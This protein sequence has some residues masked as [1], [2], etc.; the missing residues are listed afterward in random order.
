MEN[1]VRTLFLKPLIDSINCP[2]CH[3]AFFGAS[4]TQQ[5]MGYV[6]GFKKC[7]EEDIKLKES[8]ISQLGYGSLH[9]RESNLL[10]SE[11]VLPLHEKNRI[12]ICI[13]EWFTS[14]ASIL[15]EHIN[16]LLTQ[17]LSQ[18][19]LPVFLLLYNNDNR[20]ERCKTKTIYYKVA[21]ECKIPLIDIDSYIQE[22]N[23]FTPELFR[24]NTHLTE[25]GGKKV[26][27]LLYQTLTS[28]NSSIYNIKVAGR[29]V[30]VPFYYKVMSTLTVKYMGDIPSPAVRLSLTD[31]L[32]IPDNIP[33]KLL[34]LWTIAGPDSGV[35]QITN[36]KQEEDKMSIWDQWSH[37]D[38]F[39]I[40]RFRGDWYTSDQLKINLTTTPPNYSTCR[41]E[42]AEWPERF[43]WVIGWSLLTN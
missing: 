30:F 28:Y 33:G 43:F 10:L 8:T 19:I 1:K 27:E 20:V 14:E 18:H 3:I 23:L 13:L 37:Y 38:R 32:I 4:V 12:H 36:S 9:L 17:L 39:M 24:D 25:L 29:I 21:E 26:G 42:V 31:E 5:V 22:N 35:I 2:Q 11:T 16:Y 41:R 40:R 6:K 34:G 7:I 15:P